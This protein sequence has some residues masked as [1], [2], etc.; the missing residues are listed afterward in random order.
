M[1]AFHSLFLEW[2]ELTS[3]SPLPT[4][5]A[6]AAAAINATAAAAV[7]ATAAAGAAGAAAAAVNA[8]AAPPDLGEW[9]LGK[10]HNVTDSLW[11]F[12]VQPVLAASAA[13]ALTEAYS[14]YC[15]AAGHP[16][17]YWRRRRVGWWVGRL[18]ALAEGEKE[19]GEEWGE[20]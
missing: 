2:L 5:A 17:E 1:P 12:I 13:K 9:L 10:G 3:Q 6:A 11:G 4:T 20:D 15:A 19:D 14:V 18:A 8:T 7:N 16:Y